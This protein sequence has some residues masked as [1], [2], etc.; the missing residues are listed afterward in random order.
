VVLHLYSV[1]QKHHVRLKT[2]VPEADA[3]VDTL[4][5]V[6]KGANWFEREAWDL[7]GVVFTGHPNLSRILT[8]DDF[9]GHPMRK[10]I[11]RRAGTCCASRRH[12]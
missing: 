6:F 4:V 3:K 7:Y 1:S 9:V 2:N 11:R 10:T 5:S 8:H 12:G